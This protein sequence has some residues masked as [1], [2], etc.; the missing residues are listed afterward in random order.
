MSA[1]DYRRPDLERQYRMRSSSH[2]GSGG[3]GSRSG[4]CLWVVLAALLFD[5]VAVYAAVR[6]IA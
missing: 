2:S 3:G 1:D 5:A 6:V 4:G